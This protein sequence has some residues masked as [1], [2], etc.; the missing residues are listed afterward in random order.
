MLMWSMVK[1]SEFESL[2]TGVVGL[3][4]PRPAPGEGVKEG[5]GSEATTSVNAEEF[6]VV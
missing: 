5:A 6:G 1:T 4:T 2:T 3:A